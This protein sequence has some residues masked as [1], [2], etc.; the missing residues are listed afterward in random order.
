MAAPPPKH[1]AARTSRLRA[2]GR[3]TLLVYLDGQLIKDLK[4]AALDQERNVY[5]IVEEASRD[6]LAKA[7]KKQGEGEPPARRQSVKRTKPA[8][9]AK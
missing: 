7:G 2:D 8:R 1:Q 4:K 5:E 6:W 9:S 3:K